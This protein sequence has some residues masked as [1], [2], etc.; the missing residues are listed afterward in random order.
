MFECRRREL[1]GRTAH[2]QCTCKLKTKVS[3]VVS[4]YEHQIEGS[5]LTDTAEA[6]FAETDEHIEAQVAVGRTVKVFQSPE[7]VPV[8]LDVL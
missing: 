7:M 8:L 2:G 4:G 6:F 3:L 1:F 5:G